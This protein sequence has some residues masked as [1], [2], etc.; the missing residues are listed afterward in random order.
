MY[1]RNASHARIKKVGRET[2]EIIELRHMPRVVCRQRSQQS[3]F[4]F[5][6][7]LTLSHSHEESLVNDMPIFS[8][9]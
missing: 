2:R 7:R 6:R 4:F 8:K 3:F 1:L 9:L 5:E